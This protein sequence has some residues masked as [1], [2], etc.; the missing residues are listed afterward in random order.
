MKRVLSKILILMFCICFVTSCSCNKDENLIVYRNYYEQDVSTFNYLVTNSYHDVIRIANLVD[1]LVENDKY[2]NIVPSIADSWN[3]TIVGEKQLWTFY[4]KNNVYWS[5]Y[6][7]NKHSLV[8]AHDFVTTLK[9]TLNYN[10]KS[11]NYSLPSNLIE[12]AQNYYYGTL[13]NNFNYDDILTKITELEISDP[14]YQLDYYQNIKDVFDYCISSNKCT[15]D[16]D[17]VGIKAIND[18]ELQFT[19][20]KP[21]PYFLSALTYYA[22]LPTNETFVKEVGF[23]NFG[24]N[25]KSLLYNGAYILSNYSHSSRM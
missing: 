4:L 13:I 20:I 2:G 8:T 5:D 21:S 23:N 1:G 3:S 19:L 10:T 15:N 17:D 7:G 16:F 11:N 22:F 25:K 14:D 12:N 6:N 18:F 9:Y 24:T